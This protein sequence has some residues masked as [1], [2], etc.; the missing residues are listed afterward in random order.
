[1]MVDQSLPL[2]QHWMIT[3]VTER[4]SLAEKLQSGT[5][6]HGLRLE[7][8]IADKRGLSAEKRLSIYTSGYVLRLLECMR[9]DFP[10]LRSFVGDSVFDAFARAYIIS[11]PPE[12]P[13]LF[14][15]GAAFPRF[16]QKTRPVGSLDAGMSALVDLLPEIARFERA[17]TE[18]ARAPGVEDDLRT[19]SLAP[20]EILNQDPL[21]QVT[22][23]LRLLDLQFSLVDFLKR[24]AQSEQ[25]EPP[26]PRATFAAIG[27]FDYCIH[28][29][30]IQA[31]QFAFLKACESTVSL[32]AAVKRAAEKSG[33]EV[34][35]ILAELVVW[36]PIALDFGFLTRVS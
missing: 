33:R 20:F 32:H 10:G 6:Q 9:A 15:L 22:P 27:R 23:C 25:P 7:D 28:V 2:L 26:A 12:S 35:A 1:M 31:W 34:T 36:L 4:G 3:V 11:E 13:S 8:V 5:G 16:L 18:V 24:L 14:D 29:E 19:Q 30:E 21:L 17:R